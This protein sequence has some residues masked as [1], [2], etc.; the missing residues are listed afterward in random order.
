MI[1]VIGVLLVNPSKPPRRA[2]L[3]KVLLASFEPRR[4]RT[5]TG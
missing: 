3:I 4:D 2:L 5:P 1:T